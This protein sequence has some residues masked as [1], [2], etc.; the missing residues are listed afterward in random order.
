MELTN[1][2]RKMI[3]R[4]WL[5]F[6]TFVAIYSQFYLLQLSFWCNHRDQIVALIYDS[7]LIASSQ[8]L[9]MLVSSSLFRNNS[10]VYSIV[11]FR[12]DEGVLICADELSLVVGASITNYDLWRIFVW[13]DDSWLWKSASEGVWMV[14]LQWFLQHTGVEVFSD[15]VLIL[16]KS[17]YFL[18]TLRFNVDWLWCTM[19]KCESYGLSIFLQDLA[20]CSNFCVLEDSGRISNF[21]IMYISFVILSH[22][23]LLSLFFLDHSTLHEFFFWCSHFS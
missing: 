21:G 12:I 2:K 1:I 15:L 3:I 17:G 6:I 9:Q 23:L 13:H 18:K 5:K 11:L 22:L 4:V 10:W 7:L 19:F 20:A 8:V 16:R 14:G